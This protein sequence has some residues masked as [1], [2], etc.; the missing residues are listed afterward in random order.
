MR[1]FVCTLLLVLG[2]Q[3]AR[4]AVFLNGV[5]IDGVVNQTFE[6][7]TVKIDEMQTPGSTGHEQPHHL[8]WIVTEDR[9]PGVIAL[10]QPHA[11][12]T[13]HINRWPEF[14]RY[15]GSEDGGKRA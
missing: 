8:H 14:H 7:C 5:N 9:F 11:A 13:P 1:I 2:A 6:G 10:E 4:G 12:P 15:L 3:T